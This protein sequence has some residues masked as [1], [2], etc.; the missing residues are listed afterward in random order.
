[1][2]GDKVTVKVIKASRETSQVDFE[3]L[4]NLSQNN[5]Y[6]KNNFNKEN[7]KTRKS[8][9]YKNNSKSKKVNK[10]NEKKSK[11]KNK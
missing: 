4:K 7:S 1:M 9:K 5:N 11:K 10:N 6:K 8:N 3:V 2:Y